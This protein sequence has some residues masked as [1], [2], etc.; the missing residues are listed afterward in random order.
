MIRL[1]QIGALVSVLLVAMLGSCR[2]ENPED[3]S[4]VR[5]DQPLPKPATCNPSADEG[6]D[7]VP[8]KLREAHRVAAD[9]LG[10]PLEQVYFAGVDHCLWG[11]IHRFDR[12]DE[13]DSC[14][15]QVPGV[16]VCGAKVVPPWK[17]GDMDGVTHPLSP[18][19]AV[20]VAEAFVVEKMGVPLSVLERRFAPRPSGH[21][22][23]LLLGQLA[24]SGSKPGCWF[25]GAST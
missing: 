15:I 25:P 12:E 5:A 16:A 24:G 8:P 1:K 20:R 22:R 14:A 2:A 6:P 9:F 3:T 23:A 18:T 17:P 10:L 21:Q 13:W 19:D 11:D 7:S 4:G